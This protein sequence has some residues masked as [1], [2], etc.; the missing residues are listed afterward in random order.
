ML[1]ERG[2][3]R[4][5]FMPIASVEFHELKPFCAVRAPDREQC[6][7][8]ERGDAE[9]HAAN[10]SHEQPRCQQRPMS[11]SLSCAIRRCLQLWHGWCCGAGRRWALGLRGC[12][13]SLTAAPEALSA[14]TKAATVLHAPSDPR[15]PRAV[16]PSGVSRRCAQADAR[17]PRLLEAC[18]R[19]PAARRTLVSR[20]RR[21]L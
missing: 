10:C 19:C 20:R 12:R 17:S 2:V 5:D 14:Q 4:K 21:R 3:R 7:R 15:A 6:E 13:V 11:P 8:D 1:F 9:G 16:P 18:P